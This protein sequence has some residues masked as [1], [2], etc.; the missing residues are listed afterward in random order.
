MK[1]LLTLFLL[2]SFVGTGLLAQ[3]IGSPCG[4]QQG[5]S[6]WLKAFQADNDHF[7][8]GGDTTLYIAMSIHIVGKDNG[9][10]YFSQLNTLKALCTLNEFYQ[11]AGIQFIQEGEIHYINNTAYY[12]HGTVLEGAQMMFENNVPNSLNTYFVADPA[13][14]CGYNLPYAGIANAK[15]CSAPDDIT[16]AHEVGHAL[17]LPHPFLGWEGGVEWDGSVDHSFANPAPETVTYDYTYFQDTLILDTLIIDTAFVEKTDGSNCLV[18]ADGFCDTAPDYLASRWTCNANGESSTIQHDPNNMPLQSDGSLIMSYANDACQS[19]FTPQQ[20]AAMRAFLLDQRPSWLRSI[21]LLPPVEQEVTIVAPL[22]GEDIGGFG[23]ELIWEAVDNASMYLVQVSRLSSFPSA[24]T[25]QYLTAST[26]LVT[27]QLDDGRTYY[28][29]VLAYNEHQYC[30]DFNATSSFII[31]H[32][33]AIKEIETLKTIN[34]FP[35]PVDG[36]DQLMLSIEMTATWSGQL[37]LKNQLGQNILVQKIE[38]SPGRHIKSLHLDHLSKG[39]YFLTISNG[40]EQISR[41]IIVQ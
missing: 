19:R 1:F 40:I 25:F 39:L 22:A 38:L 34:I 12:Q 30:T 7:A 20:Q 36:N 24:L 14:N 9:A 16:W 41:K 11:A 32:P 31:H 15:S 18:A 35:Q 8:K 37:E 6:L 28:W 13:G 33:T 3:D 2:S 17:S 27:D 29:K 5:R 23:A 4:T 10:G 26:S 21:N